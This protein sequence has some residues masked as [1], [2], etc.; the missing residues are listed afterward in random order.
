MARNAEAEAALRRAVTIRPDLIG[1]LF[2]LAIITYQRGAYEDAENYLNRYMRL[3]QPGL[4][5]LAMGVKIARARHDR[6]AEDS[7]LQQLRRRF[8]EAPETQELLQK[9]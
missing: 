2:N 3:S 8:P 4:D 7:Y 1:A 6:A 9:R 5:G